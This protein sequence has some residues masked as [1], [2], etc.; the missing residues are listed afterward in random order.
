LCSG[1]IRDNDIDVKPDELGRDLDEA[2]AAPLRRP[3]LD[4][5]GATLDP[6]DFAQPLQQGSDP[7]ALD[8]RSGWTQVSDGRH[9]RRLLRTR[10][11]R[12][13]CGAAE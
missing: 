9:F 4:R 10:S 11:D 13:C 6:A 3:I 1:C 8:R 7:L 2:L 12:P 5:D